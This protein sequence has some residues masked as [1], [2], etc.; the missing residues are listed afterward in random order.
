MY[1]QHPHRSRQLGDVDPKDI[2]FGIG[3]TGYPTWLAWTKDVAA[4][5]G[6]ATSMPDQG[7]SRYAGLP[8]QRFP[9]A[10]IAARGFKDPLVWSTG[11][12][13]GYYLAPAKIL[14]LDT[15]HQA[16]I[17]AA[18]AAGNV[19]DNLAKAAKGLVGAGVLAALGLGALA[20]LA[21]SHR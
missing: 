13:F 16:Q 4:Q 8:A 7:G 6:L 17:Q 9:A 19:A 11:Q 1:L 14:A 5:G 12:Q 18:I 20:Y 3:Y 2:P 10:V 15:L 21:W